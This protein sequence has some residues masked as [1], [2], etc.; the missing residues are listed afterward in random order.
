MAS[1]TTIHHIARLISLSH[2]VVDEETG[3]ALRDVATDIRRS[4]KALQAENAELRERLDAVSAECERIT[5]HIDWDGTVEDL[6][7]HRPE[8]LADFIAGLIRAAGQP[9]G[10]RRSTG[11]GAD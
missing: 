1:D 2:D 3:D 5:E 9:K 6:E 4:T 10:E 8:D 11:E 7:I